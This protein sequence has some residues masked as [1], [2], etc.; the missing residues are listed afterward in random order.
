MVV[1]MEKKKTKIWEM[2]GQGM[3]RMRDELEKERETSFIHSELY[4]FPFRQ[5]RE[6]DS[7]RVDRTLSSSRR[8]GNG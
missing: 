8:D 3:R 2:R 7:A 6:R 1:A 4:S 5:Y